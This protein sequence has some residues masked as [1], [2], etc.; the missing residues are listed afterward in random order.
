MNPEFPRDLVFTAALFGVAAFVW[1]GWAQESPPRSIWWRVL[2][3]ALS[4]A[5]V[6]LA[7]LT[8]PT[9]IANWG[10]PSAL[11]PGT[12]AFITYIVVFWVEFV[13]AGV[14]AFFAIRA[15]LSDL[16]APLILAIVGV[17]FFALAPVLG[18]PVLFIPAV[19]LTLIAVGAAVLPASDVAHSFWCGVV[20]APVFLAIGAWC[21]VVGTN[22][23]N[24]T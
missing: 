13:L 4:L 5:G 23:L 19:L 15:G 2:L 14:L 6:A 18:Q 22:A 12:G 21:G 7:A 1:A 11:R 16:V 17:H 10:S 8:I 24:S 9:L 3:G 20:G